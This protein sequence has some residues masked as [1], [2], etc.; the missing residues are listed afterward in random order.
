MGEDRI[1]SVF[2][3]GYEAINAAGVKT[4]KITATVEVAD[5][6][7]ASASAHL[8]A[9]VAGLMTPATDQANG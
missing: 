3:L 5:Q 7:P 8:A 9:A 2:N 6:S 4:L 1:K